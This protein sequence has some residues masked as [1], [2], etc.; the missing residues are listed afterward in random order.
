MIN[1]MKTTA[2]IINIIYVAG[3]LII[4]PYDFRLFSV[5]TFVL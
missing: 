1:N 5:E 4:S 3:K 2:L